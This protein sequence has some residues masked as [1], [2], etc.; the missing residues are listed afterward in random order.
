MFLYLFDHYSILFAYIFLSS[1]LPLS[2]FLVRFLFW[3]VEEETNEIVFHKMDINEEQFSLGRITLR[4][5]DRQLNT[6]TWSVFDYQIGIPL[7]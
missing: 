1:N 6:V 4:V 7:H 5:D 3:A 2:E